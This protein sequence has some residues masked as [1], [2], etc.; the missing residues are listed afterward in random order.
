M[1]PS[2]E[3]TLLQHAQLVSERSTCSRNHVGVVIA[4]DGR[5][6]TSGYNG[7]PAGLPHCNHECDCDQ[8][9]KMGPGVSASLSGTELHWE[10]CNSIPP[11]TTSV[12][13][14]ANAIAYAARYGMGLEGAELFTT[15]SPCLSCA[16]LIIQAG[17]TSV[18]YVREYRDHAG[19]NLLS[20]AGIVIVG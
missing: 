2:R 10:T 1:R 11:C 13:A 6:L 9:L 17:I 12:H 18:H 19:L 14:E 7:A 8:P 16:Q 15:V 3:E 5:L 20:Q 4:R